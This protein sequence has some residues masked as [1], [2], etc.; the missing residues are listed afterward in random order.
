MLSL[1]PVCAS[2]K[3]EMRRIQNGVAVVEM[4]REPPVPY[5]GY[6]ADLF[7]CPCCG[8][9]VLSGFGHPRH[10]GGDVGEMS[11]FVAKVDKVFPVYETLEIKQKWVNEDGCTDI[12]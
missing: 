10:F 1:A 12:G 11:R 7:V 5:N 9:Q 3:V 6:Y 8:T 4:Y 2:C